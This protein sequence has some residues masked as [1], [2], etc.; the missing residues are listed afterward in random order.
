MSGGQFKRAKFHG[1]VLLDGVPA[2]ANARLKMG[3]VLVL[4][5]PEP[6]NTKPV[7][8]NIPFGVAYEDEHFLVVD[9]PALLPSSSAS[10]KTVYAAQRASLCAT[11]D[12]GGVA[13]AQSSLLQMLEGLLET[14]KRAIAITEVPFRANNVGAMRPYNLHKLRKRVYRKQ[15]H[16]LWLLPLMRMN[17]EGARY[18]GGTGTA[19][20]RLDPRRSFVGLLTSAASPPL[21]VALCYIRMALHARDLQPKSLYLH[22]CLTANG[23]IH[24]A[25][26]KWSCNVP[27]YIVACLLNGTVNVD[28]IVGS[29]MVT[30]QFALYPYTGAM[31][32]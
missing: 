12:N 24:A 14:G 30:A 32:H 25:L 2:L 16:A 29:Y 23:G 15:R 7:A 26:L 31:P 20:A 9:K 21:G 5:V 28:N 1:T 13:Q 4:C 17:G 22:C 3:Q 10:T 8:C 19:Y 6:A 27:Y 11:H 18:S